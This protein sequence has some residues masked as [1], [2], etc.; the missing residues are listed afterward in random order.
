MAACVCA[1]LTSVFVA[2]MPEMAGSVD[3]DMPKLVNSDGEAAREPRRKLIKSAI[4]RVETAKTKRLVEETIQKLERQS[5]SRSAPLA[6]HACS[7]SL[8]AAA[9]LRQIGRAH[10]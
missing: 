9:L 6:E 8:A 5:K 3:D 4:A 2:Q 1:L 7:C 10:V